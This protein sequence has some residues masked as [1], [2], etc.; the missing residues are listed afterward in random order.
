MYIRQMCDNS[1]KFSD[2]RKVNLHLSWCKLNSDA[3]MAQP[4]WLHARYQVHISSAP[5][6]K[7][8]SKLFL[9][10]VQR[11]SKIQ[12]NLWSKCAAIVLRL[13]EFG[14]SGLLSA[15]PE[16][17]RNS[18]LLCATGPNRT[19]SICYLFE[20][21]EIYASSCVLIPLLLFTLLEPFLLQIFFWKGETKSSYE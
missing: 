2:P 18:E 19:R 20:I 10:K 14:C 12:I 1:C 7:I 4:H 16:P 5:W 9:A 13:E 21:T 17:N 3:Q 6:S 15:D 8:L 11:M